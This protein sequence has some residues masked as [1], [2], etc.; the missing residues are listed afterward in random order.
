MLAQLEENPHQLLRQLRETDPVYWAPELNAWLVTRYG[1][2]VEVLKDSESFTVDDPRFTTARVTGPSMLSLDGPVH[3]RHRNAFARSLRPEALRRD[4]IDAEVSRLIEGI[5]PFGRAELR[6][7]FAGPLAAAVMGDLLA[8]DQPIG[9]ILAWYDEIVRVVA[10][11]TGSTE[12]G[13]YHTTSFRI[14]A[15]NIARA[16]RDGKSAL[17]ADAAQTLG[18]DE[19][20]SNAAVLLFGGI[21]TTEGM[22]S[23]AIL[24]TLTYGRLA[25]EESLRLEPAAAMVDRYATRDV[26][27]GGTPIRRGDQVTVSITGANRDPALFDDPDVYDPSRVN[28]GKHLA[29]AHGPHFCVGAHLARLETELAAAAIVELP[30][31]RLSGHAVPRGVVFRKPPQLHATWEVWLACW[32][33]RALPPRRFARRT[34]TSTKIT[35]KIGRDIHRL[36]CNA[37]AERH[38]LLTAS[39]RFHIKE[40]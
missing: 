26:T 32:G 20:V 34:R 24:H 6:R 21:E 37:S 19:I 35:T 31:L 8:L 25:V 38:R 1:L 27:L 28:A 9:M 2:A 22:I 16:V 17:L 18:T 14:L 11:L 5:R 39:V 33:H 12:T 3:A 10:N 13:A 29:F 36:T 30:G 4:F 15:E 23:N 7:D 40:Q